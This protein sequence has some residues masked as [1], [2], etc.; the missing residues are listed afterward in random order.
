MNADH[1]FT[2]DFSLDN[3]PQDAIGQMGAVK[4]DGKTI[5]QFFTMQQKDVAR[6]AALGQVKYNEIEMIKIFIPGDKHN[7]VESRVTDVHRAK[8]PKQYEA[9]KKMQELAPEGTLIDNWP[10]L[11]RSQVYEL[12]AANV[13]TVEQLAELSDEKLGIIGIGARSLRKHAQAFIEA[14]EKGRLPA[15][16][17]A[18]NE[19]LK[20]Q[21]AL[22]TSQIGDMAKRMEALMVKAGDRPQDAAYNPVTEARISLSK[23]TGVDL[24]IDIPANYTSLGFP[25]LKELVAQFSSAPVR[26][27]D[28]AIELIAEYQGKKNAVAA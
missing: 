20:N 1:Y 11:Q 22:L 21:V 10:L 14:T 6:T 16:M 28:E 5:P 27:K 26:N 13:F 25:K 19:S 2:R 4:A 12:K 18:E 3:L 9:F 7:I 15:Q 8:Y 17:I 24:T 23:A